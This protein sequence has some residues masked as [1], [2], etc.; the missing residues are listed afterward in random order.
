MRKF[1]LLS[2]LLLSLQ[3]PVT[4]QGVKANTDPLKSKF[5]AGQDV[6]TSPDQLKSKF[7]AA[8][9]AEWDQIFA[10]HK[11]EIKDTLVD[12]WRTQAIALYGTNEIIPAHLLIDVCLHLSNLL[13]NVD[14]NGMCLLAKAEIYFQEKDYTH[15][16]D[17]AQ[18][19]GKAFI[20]SKNTYQLARSKNRMARS[21]HY[22]QQDQ[23]SVK[24][25]E[26]AIALKK[27]LIKAEP[28]NKSV[29][30]TLWKVD[31][32]AT[33]LLMADFYRNIKTMDSVDALRSAQITLSKNPKFVHPYYWAAV[34]L[35]GDWR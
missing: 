26:E 12:R 21:Y 1:I 11:T 10:A 19:A 4:G 15:A 34:V 22:S 17:F 32:E 29:V 3:Y 20:Q 33:S 18:R 14:L 2:A 30:A 31:D 16:I 24:A 25:F 23:N 28:E 5:V 9:A 7:L 8:P 6:K 27:Q 35:L 13:Q